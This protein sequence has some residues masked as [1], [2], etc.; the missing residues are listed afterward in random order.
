MVTLILDYSLR[1]V[2]VFLV[3]NLNGG[4]QV[5]YDNI[6]ALCDKKKINISTLEKKAGLGNGT[7]GGWKT[8]SPTLSSLQAVAK[9]LNVKVSTLL[10]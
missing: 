5:I 4:E 6:K 8:A 3:K 7:I 9:V 10:K 1:K 2:N